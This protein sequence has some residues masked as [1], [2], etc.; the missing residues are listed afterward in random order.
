MGGAT[1]PGLKGAI[2]RIE[3]FTTSF[4]P[5]VA[6]RLAP[7]I[8]RR[9]ETAFATQT[10]IYNRPQPPLAE[11][12]LR[13]KRNT[14]GGSHILQRF[15][16]LVNGTYTLYTGNRVVITIG[17]SGQYAHEGDSGRGNRPPRLLLPSLGMPKLWKDDAE[18]ATD[19]VVKAANI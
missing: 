11:S 8:N 6:K 18:A 14:P 17:E 7:K 1:S 15:F 4:R 3:K 19:E 2:S 16:D 5:A 9:Y 13:R 10:N 12:T